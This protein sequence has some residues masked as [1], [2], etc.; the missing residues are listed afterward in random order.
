MNRRS[1]APFACLVAALVA[2]LLSCR[3]GTPATDGAPPPASP[4]AAPSG[5]GARAASARAHWDG[6][7]SFRFYST[8]F[9]FELGGTQVLAVDETGRVRDLFVRH[10][11]VPIK[12]Y[13]SD[14][15]PERVDACRD[16]VKSGQKDVGTH[17]WFLADYT[18]SAEALAT[19]RRTLFTADL[20]ALEPHYSGNDGE[21]GTTHGYFLSTREGRVV[22][23][24]YSTGAPA[25]P[26]RLFAVRSFLL[27][28]QTAHEDA[29]KRAPEVSYVVVTAMLAEAEGKPGPDSGVP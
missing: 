16:L 15:G 6:K 5:N 23:S 2:S 4:A 8:D 12:T 18:L 17:R 14:A 13:C 1:I 21:D 19:F 29:R 20:G 9:H 10:E 28:Q 24:G 22:V 26:P 27:D 3:S 11:I 7:G 25:E